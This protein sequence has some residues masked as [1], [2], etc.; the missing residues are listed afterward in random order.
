MGGQR[1]R[2]PLAQCRSGCTRPWAGIDPAPQWFDIAREFTE[3]WV[4]HQQIRD[5]VGAGDADP[6]AVAVVLDVF[7]RGLPHALRNNSHPCSSW[8]SVVAEGPVSVGWILQ[9]ERGGWGISTEPAPDGS[10]EVSYP[11]EFLWR[12]WIRDPRATFDNIE[13][14]GRIRTAIVDYVA[15]I[16]S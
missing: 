2:R 10:L 1:A 5:A 14:A 8:V 12:R 4:H 3:Y 11:A 16:R 6:V 13:Q 9:Y 7:A 15:I